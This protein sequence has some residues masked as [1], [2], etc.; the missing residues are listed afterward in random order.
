MARS[1]IDTEIKMRRRGF[2]LVVGLD[3]AGRGPLAGPVTAGAFAVLDTGFRDERA[4]AAL[5]GVRDSKQLP[6]ARREELYGI[7]TNHG[8]FAWGEGLV[9][10][11]AIDRIN[12]YEASKLAMAKAASDLMARLAKDGLAFDPAEVCL[13]LDGNFKIGLPFF[14][15][16]VIKGDQL[17][18][19]C[20]AASIIAKVKRDRIMA[21]CARKYPGY[22]FERNKGYPTKK[23]LLALRDLGVLPIHRKTFAPVKS[24]CDNL[25]NKQVFND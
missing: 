3:E 14:Q 18:F 9:G 16:P 11:A 23:H 24:L 15:Q 1:R 19:S 10:N 7:L 13:I 6:A 4:R 12:I 17:V 21:A 8:N 2:R 20:S 25:N 22:D 5:A